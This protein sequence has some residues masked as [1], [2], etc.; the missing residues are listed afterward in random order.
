MTPA[1]TEFDTPVKAKH[2][3]YISIPTASAAQEVLAHAVVQNTVLSTADKKVLLQV[4]QEY[5]A[6][7]GSPYYGQVIRSIISKAGVEGGELD[8][9]S[10]E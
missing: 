2:Y 3:T 7:S 5:L 1:E 9:V 8:Y 6:D 4:S 10:A